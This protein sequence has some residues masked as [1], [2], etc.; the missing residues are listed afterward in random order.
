MSLVLRRQCNLLW[1]KCDTGLEVFPILNHFKSNYGIQYLSPWGSPKFHD[2]PPTSSFVISLI[3]GT[4]QSVR[5]ISGNFLGLNCPPSSASASASKYLSWSH[6]KSIS[7]FPILDRIFKLP[8][9]II[10]HRILL[11]LKNY[12]PHIYMNEIFIE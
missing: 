6:P 12:S 1:N 3:P 5:M 8:N 7:S 2:Q 4:V 11:F 9:W 10:N